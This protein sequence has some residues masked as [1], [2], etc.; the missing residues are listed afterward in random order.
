MEQITVTSC[1]IGESPQPVLLYPYF[2]GALFDCACRTEEKQSVFAFIRYGLNVVITND[3]LV[4]EILAVDNVGDLDTLLQRIVMDYLRDNPTTL[5][6]LTE[7]WRLL[8][9][10]QGREAKIKEIRNAFTSC[11][12]L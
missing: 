2:M 6:T 10:T 7:G 5:E 1:I 12:L 11:G 9:V 3:N 4:E 8:G